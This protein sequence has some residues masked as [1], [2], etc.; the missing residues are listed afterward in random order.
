L[1]RVN[2]RDRRIHS[3]QKAG[4]AILATVVVG[5]FMTKAGGRLIHVRTGG[6]AKRLSI[7]KVARW[8][9]ADVLGK[10]KRETQ[11]EESVSTGRRFEA[12]CGR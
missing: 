2:G 4:R 6:R 5:F 8:D 1:P 9:L 7:R 12:L 10:Q 3:K 11:A